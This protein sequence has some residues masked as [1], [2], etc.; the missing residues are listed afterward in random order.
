[1]AKKKEIN[2]EVLFREEYQSTEFSPIHTAIAVILIIIFIIFSFRYFNANKH[3]ISHWN[4]LTIVA[5]MG[6]ITFM[7]VKYGRLYEVKKDALYIYN[8]NKKRI[9]Y[10]ISF[11]GIS[12]L[13]VEVRNKYH[14]GSTVKYGVKTKE[15]SNY[16]CHG[17]RIK[18]SNGDEVFVGSNKKEELLSAIKIAIQ[19]A[20]SVPQNQEVKVQ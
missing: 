16:G 20:N 2:K 9:I 14:D 3:F 5:L 8:F 17:V 13:S 7:L 10:R 12:C 4:Y 19:N 11:D 1:M 15:D 18:Y 6:Y